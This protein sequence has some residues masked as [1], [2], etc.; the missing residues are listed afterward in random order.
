MKNLKHQPG[1]VKVRPELSDVDVTIL[2]VRRSSEFNRQGKRHI[3]FGSHSSPRPEHESKKLKAS[4]ASFMETNRHSN[5]WWF[6]GEGWSRFG[7]F[8]VVGCIFDTNGF[9]LCSHNSDGPSRS[10]PSC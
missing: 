6:W 3:Q 5:A 1:F 4:A 2:Y 7:A 8:G 9:M 10:L